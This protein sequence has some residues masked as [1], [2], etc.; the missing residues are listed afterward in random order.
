MYPIPTRK[1]E[2]F[3]VVAYGLLL[4]LLLGGASHSWLAPAL[5]LA[6]AL[7]LLSGWAHGL[8]LRQLPAATLPTASE[9]FQARRQA[10]MAT[11]AGKLHAGIDLLVWLPP[12]AGLVLKGPWPSLEFPVAYATTRHAFTLAA[13]MRQRAHAGVQ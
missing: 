12:L 6:L 4:A 7:G 11:G 5:G 13:L 1:G 2:A 9:D 10:F 8:A 3:A